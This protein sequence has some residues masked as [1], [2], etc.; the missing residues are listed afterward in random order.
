MKCPVC[1]EE[2]RVGRVKDGF[3]FCKTCPLSVHYN[4]DA[5]AM[6]VPP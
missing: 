4:T 1:G 3:W 2:L 5:M 6:Q